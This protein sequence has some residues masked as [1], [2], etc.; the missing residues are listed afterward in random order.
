MFYHN[1]FDMVL[2]GFQWHF[3]HFNKRGNSFQAPHMSQSVEEEI[4]YIE[5]MVINDHLMVS[6]TK[7]KEEVAF[8]LLLLSSDFISLQNTIKAKSIVQFACGVTLPDGWFDLRSKHFPD[9]F[10]D[11]KL[12]MLP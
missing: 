1:D 8:L 11:L 3:V 12:V 6:H 4:K 7:S 10:V 9:N 5:L 2:P